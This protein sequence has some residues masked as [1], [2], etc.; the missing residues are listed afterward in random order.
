MKKVICPA[1][2]HDMEESAEAFD[3]NGAEVAGIPHFACPLCNEITFTPSQLDMVFGYRTAQRQLFDGRPL[4]QD[5]S[6]RIRLK[7]R[8]ILSRHAYQEGL[9]ANEDISAS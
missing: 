2:G 1:C 9:G 4:V 3:V 6:D 8:A 5:P 7:V